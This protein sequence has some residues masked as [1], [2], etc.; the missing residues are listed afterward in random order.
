MYSLSSQALQ[1]AQVTPAS[2]SELFSHHK[3]VLLVLTSLF[4]MLFLQLFLDVNAGFL[5]N[6]AA[7]CSDQ[8]F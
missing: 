3:H 4:L 7:I 8:A 5:V 1:S 2:A 6:C